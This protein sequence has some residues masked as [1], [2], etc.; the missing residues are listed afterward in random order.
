MT[1]KQKLWEALIV[2]TIALFLTV[3]TNII[4]NWAGYCMK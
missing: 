2:L 4:L 1:F 3:A